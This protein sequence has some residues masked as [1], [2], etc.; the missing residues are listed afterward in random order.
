MGFFKQMNLARFIMLGSLVLSAV[1]AYAGWFGIAAFGW[2]GHAQVTELNDD[3]EG[4]VKNLSRDISRYSRQHTELSRAINKDGL[5][6]QDSPQSYIMSI[7][8][9]DFVELGNVEINPRERP[10][11][12][13][14]VD[15][16]WEIK[17]DPSRD[18][19]RSQISNFLYQ[20]EAKSRRMKVTDVKIEKFQKRVKPHEI[21]E[22]KWT[23][24]ATVTSREA[25]E[26]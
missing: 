4:R 3:L 24:T 13:T 2:P 19:H 17:A 1:I 9:E 11:S 26:G 21:P 23:F 25:V 14:V 15:K 18:Y 20:L 7:A 8:A 6:N 10:I 16:T 12:K 22:D 5:R